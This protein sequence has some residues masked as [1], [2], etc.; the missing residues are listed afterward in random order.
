MA[1]K[2]TPGARERILDVAERLF[3][4]HGVRAVG[5]Q[6]VIDEC[7]CGKNLLYREFGSKDELVLAYL[8]R[9]AEQWTALVDGAV[10]PLAGDPAGQLVAI[11]EAVV[12]EIA[13]PGYRGCPF[14]NTNAE[15]P[16][17][18]HLVHRAAVEHRSSLRVQL[19]SLA[20]QAGAADPATLA[21]RLLLI[22]DGLYANGAILGRA[23]AARA[24]VGFARDV[25]AQATQPLPAAASR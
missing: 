16:D 10:R 1:R 14:L 22:I 12:A 3:S 25:V 19:H 13:D 7:G 21:D 4:Q 8:E 18:D 9:S 20:E 5:L 11:V 17:P 24:A 23:G 2:P 6:Q 15:F